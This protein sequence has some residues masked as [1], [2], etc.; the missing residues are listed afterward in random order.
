MS[1]MVHG[2][3]L[4]R[5]CL[6]ALVLMTAAGSAIAANDKKDGKDQTRRLLQKIS[7]LEQAKSRME[8][9]LKETS[10][11]FELAKQ[12]AATA[13]RK[14]A[15]LGKALKTAEDE[16]A[17]LVAKLAQAEQKLSETAETLR[18]TQEARGQLET[19]LS[20][21]TQEFSACTT[22]NESLHRVGVDLIKQ[23]QEKGCLSSLLQKEPLTQLKS[24][25]A[26]NMIEEYR[27]KLDQEAMSQPLEERQQPP[28]QKGE[29]Q[30]VEAQKVEAQKV[31]TQEASPEKIEQ[32]KTAPEKTET[33]KARQ[34]STL[35]RIT[36]KVKQFFNDTEW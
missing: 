30:K 29:A 21:R 8:G 9:Q 32:Q 28:P 22:K 10:E 25:E 20:E 1:S 14:G 23:Y 13:S 6:L 36:R 26:E 4:N 18:L 17:E 16:K 15:S 5:A 11:Q 24:A 27:E 35:D 31:E 2:S 3:R 12:G 19:S 34:Q 33:V 7:A